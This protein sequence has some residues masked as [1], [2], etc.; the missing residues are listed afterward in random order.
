MSHKNCWAW[1]F[2]PNKFGLMYKTLYWPK[3]WLF[4]TNFVHMSQDYLFS[5]KICFS[6]S[7]QIVQMSIISHDATALSN[8]NKF[9]L[10]FHK[11]CSVNNFIL[12]KGCH[13]SFWAWLFNPNKSSLMTKVSPN[14]CC[15]CVF[16]DHLAAVYSGKPL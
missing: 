8:P 4:K 13:I 3:I 2:N 1:V 15:N 14:S 9:G 7:Q 16:C 6:K 5:I 12:S 10:M 11:N